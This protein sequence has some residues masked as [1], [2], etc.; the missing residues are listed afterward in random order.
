MTVAP[1]SV[2]VSVSS[3]PDPPVL[4]D[5]HESVEVTFTASASGGT[6]S[7]AYSWSGDVSGSGE[8]ISASFSKRGTVSGNVEV[9]TTAQE[10]ATGTG[11]I[12]IYQLTSRPCWRDSPRG[13]HYGYDWWAPEGSDACAFK[14]G[15]VRAIGVGEKEGYFVIIINDDETEG[16]YYHFQENSII[17][18]RVTE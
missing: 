1:L 14:S 12:T 5:D 16:Q 17:E 3:E 10:E 4:D 13:P 11:S 6:G 9:T 2:S 15:V 18:N 7:Y 8:S